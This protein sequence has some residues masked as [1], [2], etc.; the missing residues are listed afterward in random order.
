M[1]NKL[2]TLMMIAM[3]AAPAFAGRTLPIDGA[4]TLDRLVAQLAPLPYPEAMQVLEA[5]TNWSQIPAAAKFADA[6]PG[7]TGQD[8]NAALKQANLKL[9]PS[10][11]ALMADRVALDGLAQNMNWT[12]AIGQAELTQPFDVQAAMQ[13]LH[14]A[15]QN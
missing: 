7:L 6:N 5:A 4:L 8:L 2:A 1:K 9:D 3:C 11:V 13:S 12:A 14:V 10:A 15:P